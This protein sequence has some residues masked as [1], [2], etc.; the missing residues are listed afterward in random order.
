VESKDL[1]FDKLLMLE[2]DIVK[3]QDEELEKS[4]MEIDKEEL[5]TP[6]E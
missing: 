4:F 6:E 3:L 1:A 5:M 2:A